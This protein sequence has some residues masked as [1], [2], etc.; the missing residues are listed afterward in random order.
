[1]GWGQEKDT[2]V[3]T[4]SPYLG[5]FWRDVILLMKSTFRN[6]SLKLRVQLMSK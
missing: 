5:I 1:M 4:Q 6:V 2:F 3:I